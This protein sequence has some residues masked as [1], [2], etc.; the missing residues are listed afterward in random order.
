VHTRLGTPI[1]D[2]DAMTEEDD[3]RRSYA[4]VVPDEK[5]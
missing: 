3:F 2:V 5:N 4:K 1:A